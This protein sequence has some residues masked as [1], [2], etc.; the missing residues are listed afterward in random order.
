MRAW[1]RA[2][3]RCL[4]GRV[5]VIGLVVISEQASRVNEM[6]AELEVKGLLCGEVQKCRR[7]RQGGLE[8]CG[9]TSCP[10]VVVSVGNGSE[11][12]GVISRVLY[13]DVAIEDGL[14][15]PWSSI[16]SQQDPLE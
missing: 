15:R 9:R 5:I 10:G 12:A 3:K 1:Q 16:P 8:A 6:V 4:E 11:L 2:K 13:C 14:G 7:C